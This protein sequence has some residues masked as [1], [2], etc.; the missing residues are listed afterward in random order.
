MDVRGKTWGFRLVLE[1]EECGVGF[2]EDMAR[3]GIIDEVGGRE[4]LDWAVKSARLWRESSDVQR[5]GVTAEV[6]LHA[7]EESVRSVLHPREGEVPWLWAVDP[8]FS[9]VGA[10]NMGYQGRLKVTVR[11]VF[12]ELWVGIYEE[13]LESLW[14]SEREIWDSWIL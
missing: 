7:D 2:I 13:D 10:A 6:V 11:A 8:S 14:S 1:E 9:V 4:G 12:T 3:K 5:E